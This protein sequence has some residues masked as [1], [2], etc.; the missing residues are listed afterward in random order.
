MK[1]V[2][3]WEVPEKVLKVSVLS[4]GSWPMHEEGEIGR[5]VGGKA[6]FVEDGDRES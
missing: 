3:R 1:G 4:K 2:E 5:R 6:R